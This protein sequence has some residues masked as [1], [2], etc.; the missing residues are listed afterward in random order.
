MATRFSARV[1]IISVV[2]VI[3]DG[4]HWRCAEPEV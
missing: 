3:N 1:I 4:V 2:V